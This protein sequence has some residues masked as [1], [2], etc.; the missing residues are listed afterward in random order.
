[1]KRHILPELGNLDLVEVSLRWRHYDRTLDPLGGLSLEHTKTGV[2]R[3]VPV[4]PALA[5]V[6]AEW[7]LAGCERTYGRPPVDGDLV[8]PTR[9]GTER[10]S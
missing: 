4:Y 9:N 7:K 6:L 10:T 1:M 3:L 2:A 8:V 5:R